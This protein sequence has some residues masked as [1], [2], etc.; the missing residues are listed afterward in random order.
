MI[1]WFTLIENSKLT[2]NHHVNPIVST[3]GSTEMGKE[4]NHAPIFLLIIIANNAAFTQKNVLIKNAVEAGL[5][6][7][8]RPVRLQI[9][10]MLVFHIHIY[11]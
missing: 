7:T 1:A 2:W 8:A 10:S 9:G 4:I 6:H 5:T 11:I 3:Y